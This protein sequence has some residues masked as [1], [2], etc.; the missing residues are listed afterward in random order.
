MK[1]LNYLAL[2]VLG[3]VFISCGGKKSE[4]KES[5]ETEV[6]EAS[7]TDCLITDLN[8]IDAKKNIAKKGTKDLYTGLAVEKDQNDSIIRKVEIKNGWLIKDIKLK[9][10]NNKYITNSEFNYENGKITNKFEL[11]IEDFCCNDKNNKFCYVNTYVP[12]NYEYD[13][14]YYHVMAS[15]SSYDN[16]YQVDF[17]GSAKASPN[18][19][20]DFEKNDGLRADGTQAWIA[21][22]ISSE[23]MYQILDA[24]K[25]ELPHFDYWKN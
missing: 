8:G 10:I 23:K 14:T 13:D 3:V 7:S 9:K 21:R 1:R 16:A 18:F 19:L 24:M 17:I 4:S 15:Y 11:E 2:L 5:K 20:K 6:K 25:K 22:E 12:T